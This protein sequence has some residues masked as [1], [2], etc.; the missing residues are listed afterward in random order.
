MINDDIL[1]EFASGI[2][3]SDVHNYI[4]THKKEYETW[5]KN[6]ITKNKRKSKKETRLTI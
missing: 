6:N 2:L 1:K 5:Q 3:I 4:S